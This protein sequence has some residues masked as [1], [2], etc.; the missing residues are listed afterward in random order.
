MEYG[1]KTLILID[2]SA[3][4]SM[5]NREIVKETLKYL[6]RH[7]MSE[8][9]FALATYTG[10]TELLVGYGSAQEDY[11]DAI[12]KIV[13]VEKDTCLPDVLMHTLTEWRDADFAMRSILVF[14]DGLGAESQTYPVEEV[15]F[16]LNES[17]Y[18]LY[19]VGLTQQTNQMQ[20]NRAA[21]MARIS[22]GKYFP[23]DFEDSEAEVERKLTEQILSAMQE[24]RR[25]DADAGAAETAAGENQPAEEEAAADPLTEE[26]EQEENLA[27]YAEEVSAGTLT[28]TGQ[29]TVL[30]GAIAAGITA[31]ILLLL[32]LIRYLGRKHVSETAGV[33]GSREPEVREITLEDLNDP[34]RFFHMPIL[35]SI[36]IGKNR[37]EA[38]V[39]IEHDE[40]VSD[41]HC[42]LL[43]R[44][45]KCFLRDLASEKGTYLNGERIYREMELHSADVITVGRAKLMVKL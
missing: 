18:P 14:T 30:F 35:R 44:D 37:R 43:R 6:I 19:V 29:G 11:L 17:G 39:C 25:E 15:Y 1:Y 27:A 3:S 13:Y 32:M 22:H 2:N 26:Y 9:D 12:E 40:D 10:Q 42:E 36:V 41:R 28:K 4:V 21:S 24:A 8:N 38:D 7:G 31:V 20:L 23:T 45:E 16:R 33:P 34:M 5:G